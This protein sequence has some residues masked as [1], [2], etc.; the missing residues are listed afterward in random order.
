M[1]SFIPLESVKFNKK[2]VSIKEYPDRVMLEF[3]DGEIATHS[4]LAGSDG[5]SSTVREYL[6][7][8]LYPEEA[9]PVY[10]G[11]YCYRAVIPMEEAYEIIG[12]KTD[13]AKVFF[14]RNR[15]AVS[16]RITGGKVR[17]CSRDD[18]GGQKHALITIIACRSGTSFSSKLHRAC[19]GRTQAGSPS[20]SQ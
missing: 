1:T 15:G 19:L 11:A 9:I 10:S 8:P 14:G 3:E 4:I 2:L 13:V 5:I 18:S 7:K 20:P 12:D 16:Y 17:C 6:L